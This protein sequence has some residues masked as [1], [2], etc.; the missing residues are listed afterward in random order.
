MLNCME[1][2]PLAVTRHHIPTLGVTNPTS[3]LSKDLVIY[4]ESKMKRCHPV[5]FF[6]TVICTHPDRELFVS[7]N[8]HTTLKAK[9]QQNEIVACYLLVQIWKVLLWYHSGLRNMSTCL[10]SAILLLIQMQY[11]STFGN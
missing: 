2:V 4:I 10:L 11:A 8:G 1:D 3:C 6:L 7:C 5:G 9:A